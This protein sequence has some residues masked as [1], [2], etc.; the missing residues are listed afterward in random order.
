MVGD[1]VATMYISFWLR[2]ISNNANDLIWVGFAVNTLAGI[3]GFFLVESPAWL[4]SVGRKQ[5]AIKA[6]KYVAKMN[7][8]GDMEI[9][10]IKEEKF[11]T[12]DPEKEKKEN[13]KITGGVADDEIQE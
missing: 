6:L 3:L 4:L 9:I 8:H 10:D 1:I 13:E 5:D 2:Y 11:E 12:V 7:G